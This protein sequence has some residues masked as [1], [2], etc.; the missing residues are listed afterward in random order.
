MFEI[1]RR[2][3]AKLYELIDRS[4][5]YDNPIE[6]ESRSL[7]NVPFTLV[8]DALDER[9]LEEAEV[10]ELIEPE[11]SQVGRRNARKPIQCGGG[12]ICSRPV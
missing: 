10:R 4:D 9:F 3:A 7:M 12:I 8:D 11:G 2:K 1:N 6:V 5:F